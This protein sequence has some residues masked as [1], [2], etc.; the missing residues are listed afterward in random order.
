MSKRL[1]TNEI[2]FAIAVETA[3]AMQTAQ[4]MVKDA[5]LAARAKQT[6]EQQTQCRNCQAALENFILDYPDARAEAIDETHRDI[7]ENCPA[8]RAEYVKVL[9]AQFDDCQDTLD[10]W[11]DANAPETDEYN[12]LDVH[13]FNGDDDRWQNGGVK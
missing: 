9:D 12:A 8:C 13:C 3:Q 4:A 6:A 7:W 2:A 11:A 1:T 10:E 5:E